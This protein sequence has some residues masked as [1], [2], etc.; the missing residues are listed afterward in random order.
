[1]PRGSASSTFFAIPR[2]MA[3][4]AAAESALSSSSW[5]KKAWGFQ[6]GPE[7]TVGKKREYRT[8]PPR[9]P[10]AGVKAPV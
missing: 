5:G 7:V 3:Y 10:G 4:S 6:M 9:L 8:K 1:M 2:E